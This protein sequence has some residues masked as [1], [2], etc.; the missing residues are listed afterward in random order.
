MILG[1]PGSPA[2]LQGAPPLTG[3]RTV[4]V[5]IAIVT[6]NSNRWIERCL[7]ALPAACGDVSYE[8]I[9]YDNHSHDPTLATI[10]RLLSEVGSSGAGP[11][12]RIIES[13][14]NDGFAGAMNR[15]ASQAT[16]RFL[17]LLNPDCRLAPGSIHELCRFLDAH[18]E[19]AAAAPL[20]THEN[21][22]DQREFQ[23]RRLPTLRSM[24]LEV[25]F[26]RSSGRYASLD[27][28]GPQPVEQPAAAALLIRRT[29]FDEVGGLDEQFSPAWFEDVDLCQRLA[30]AGQRM[31]VVPA[32]T[33]K[34]FG[35]A[36]LEHLPFA[37]FID[38]WYRNMWRYGRKWLTPGQAEALRW[39]IIC[40]M[41]LRSVAALAGIAHREAGRLTAM[42]AYAAVLRKAFHSWQP[43]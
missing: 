22:D 6:W 16:G 7:R 36:S 43:K 40:G 18:P 19:V 1:E 13:P 12:H 3:S 2:P 8:V 30:R 32:A 28:S 27:L 10:G 21:G 33:A 4:D 14:R 31:F 41:L 11:Q 17:F 42:R 24:V 25:L 38:L 34:H 9:V 35:G 20:L 26:H 29:I 37:S 39:A 23:L 5:T 15:S